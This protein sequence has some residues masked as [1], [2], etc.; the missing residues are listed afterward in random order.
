MSIS[1]ALHIFLRRQLKV[2]SAMFF[3]S[4]TYLTLKCYTSDR[5]FYINTCCIWYNVI[6][7]ILIGYNQLPGELQALFNLRLLFL[8]FVCLFIILRQMAYSILEHVMQ[9]KEFE[10][11][12]A[13]YNDNA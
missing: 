5:P 2:A 12:T 13:Y 10:L 9:S 3:L 7:L 4:C 6:I 11:Q 1:F 8:G